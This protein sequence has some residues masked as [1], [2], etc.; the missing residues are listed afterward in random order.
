VLPARPA[1]PGLRVQRA[2]PQGDHVCLLPLSLRLSDGATFF[3]AT[4]VGP[5]ELAGSKIT[6]SPFSAYHGTNEFK[7][8]DIVKVVDFFSKVDLAKICRLKM[9]IR[10]I[11]EVKAFSQKVGRPQELAIFMTFNYPDTQEDSSRAQPPP[12]PIDRILEERE[13]FPTPEPEIKI[14]EDESRGSLPA[15]LRR[16]R[17][18][19]SIR[20]CR[21]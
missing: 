6:V 12:E 10:K 21:F 20:S 3:D 13:V 8:Y 11:V 1:D 9:M 2:Q 17:W 4:L 19:R 15:S 5:Y 14:C 16:R 18:G 7:K